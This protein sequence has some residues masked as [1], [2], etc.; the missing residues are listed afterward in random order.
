MGPFT[1]VPVW[2]IEDA[3][4]YIA[5]AAMIFYIIKREPRPVVTLMEMFALTVLY[6]AMYENLATYQ[7]WYGYGRSFIMVFNVPLSVPLFEFLFLYSALKL[8]ERTRVP[9]WLKPIG[10][11]F[12]AVVADFTLDPVS[13]KQVFHTLEGTLARWTWYPQ[14]GWVQIYQEP[15]KNFTGWM[16]IIGL[17]ATFFLLGR[18]WHKKA[19]YS[20]VVGYLYP[21]LGSIAALLVLVT[22]LS[23]FLLNLWPFFPE[24]SAAEWV[25]LIVVLVVPPILFVIFWHGRMTDGYS[26]KGD[27]PLFFALGGFPILNVLFTLIG[28]YTQILWLEIVF[29]VVMEAA[30]AVI[31]VA[32]RRHQ[33][34]QT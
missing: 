15:V 27:F 26:I 28:G 34:R 5:T 21:I 18:W 10:A 11:G 17:G 2:V 8:F 33:G 30:L 14:A 6:A 13:V 19:N 3:V 12:L 29:L 4:T 31:Y 24:G 32:G 7:K 16:V 22:P 25:M 20:T 1:F 9:T 23:S